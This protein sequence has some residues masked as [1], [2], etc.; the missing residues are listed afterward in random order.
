MKR[1]NRIW[2]K[3]F[4]ASGL[5]ALGSVLAITTS[6]AD[7]S[8]NCRAYAED[9]SVR[10]QQPAFGTTFSA[11]MGDLP[12]VRWLPTGRD[13][14]KDLHSS[15]ALTHIACRIDGREDIRSALPR[16]KG[17]ETGFN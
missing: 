4:V 3:V 10:I 12:V 8:A 14:Y 9:H 1:R 11:S 16:C 7:T 15:T 13:D 6:L 5:A 17:G 2:K